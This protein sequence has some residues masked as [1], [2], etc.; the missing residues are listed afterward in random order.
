MK[1]FSL[2]SGIGGFDL[3][4][5]REGHEI[6]GACEIDKY[7]RQVYAKHFQGV[8]LHEDATKIKPEELPDF[9]ILCAGFP[10]QPFSHAGRKNGFKDTR[11]TLF[12][13]IARI[14]KEKKPRYLLLENV[15]GLLSH[16]KGNTFR[17]ILRT[18]NELGYDAE[19][20]IIDSKYFVPHERK[21]L[22]IIGHLRGQNTRQIFPLGEISENSIKINKIKYYHKSNSQAY[23]VYNIEGVCPTLGAGHAM[24]QPLI[25]Q[26]NRIRRLM[27]VEC[28]RL[29]G[30]PDDYGKEISDT[31]RYSVIGNAVT[32]PVIEKIMKELSLN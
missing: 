13:E 18:L 25:I 1:I 5:K 28:E 21:R 12:F 17:T 4:A 32:V 30:L 31:N 8:P 2:F 26:K 11:G 14:A 22:F 3:A 20:Q 16:S 29:Q 10:C 15:K 9:D 27:P 7:A 19:W 6:V 23:R 24:S